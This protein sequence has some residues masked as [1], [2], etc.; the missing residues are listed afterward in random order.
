MTMSK[1][2][3]RELFAAIWVGIALQV[4]GQAID[5]RWHATHKIFEAPSD[6]L[7]AHW[8]LWI[9]TLVTLAAASLAVQVFGRGQNAGLVMT[10]AAGTGYVA[11]SIWHFLEHAGS[12]DPGLPHILLAVT[13]LATLIGVVWATVQWRTS[14]RTARA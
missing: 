10:V 9:G 5:L 11:V 6:Q 1:S 12:A 3:G 13:K 8:V 7:R 2:R 14:R 4:L